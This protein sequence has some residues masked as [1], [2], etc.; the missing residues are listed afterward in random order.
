M[1]LKSLY[2]THREIVIVIVTYGKDYPSAKV[3]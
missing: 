1:P 3:L 2:E